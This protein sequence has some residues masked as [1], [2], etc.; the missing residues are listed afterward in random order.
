MNKLVILLIIFEA[1]V[2]TAGCIESSK[3]N[4]TNPQEV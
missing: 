2:L 4:V 1:V 3:A